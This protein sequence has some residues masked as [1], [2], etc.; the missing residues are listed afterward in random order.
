MTPTEPSYREIHLSNGY[1]CKI[2]SEDYSIISRFSW[3]G[4][5]ARED[6]P[7]YAVRQI[8]LDDGSTHW[9]RMHRQILGIQRGEKGK[10]CDHINH[11]TLDNRR[12][13]LRVVNMRENNCN[14]R[15]GKC[16][17]SGFKGVSYPKSGKKWRATIS[18]NGGQRHLG[19]FENPEEAYA[20]Y[21]KAA[22]EIQGEY[23]CLG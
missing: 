22:R 20:A 1:V 5:K 3:F 12:D 17:T 8:F 7:V 6:S 9:V 10:F 23:A 21:C 16:N 4:R 18:L 14:L 2:S 15:K 11:D 13:N 19:L